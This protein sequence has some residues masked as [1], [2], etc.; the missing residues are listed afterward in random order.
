MKIIVSLI[1]IASFNF[2][3]V[4]NKDVYICDSKGAKKYHFTKTCR[5][6]SACKHEIVKKTLSEA[7]DLGLTICG[8]ED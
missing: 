8:W 6:L 5:G 7:K 4:E 3:N 2:H 1:L